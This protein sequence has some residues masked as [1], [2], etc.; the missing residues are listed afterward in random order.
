MLYGDTNLV[1]LVTVSQAQLTNAIKHLATFCASRGVSEEVM[2]QNLKELRGL[3]L[4]ALKRRAAMVAQVGQSEQR[5]L[6]TMAKRGCT[7]AGHNCNCT[8]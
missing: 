7:L 2:A 3:D 6:S 8:V 1:P 5:Y 4:E